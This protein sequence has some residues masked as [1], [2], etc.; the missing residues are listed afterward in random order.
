MPVASSGQDNPVISGGSAPHSPLL[1]STTPQSS[2]ESTQHRVTAATTADSVVRLES[3]HARATSRLEPTF[4]RDEP[5][6]SPA[7]PSPFPAAQAHA[8]TSTAL[9]LRSTSPSKLS[10][11][12]P[13]QASSGKTPQLIKFVQ[14]GNLDELQRLVDNAGVKPHEVCDELGANA[15]HWAASKGHLDVVMWLVNRR[16][17]VSGCRLHLEAEPVVA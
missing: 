15:L 5:Q 6:P 4:T 16:C 12:A 17:F 11:D 13:S 3:L 14:E 10:D 8:T 9:S 2:P 7:L 1:A